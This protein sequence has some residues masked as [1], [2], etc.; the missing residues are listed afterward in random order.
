MTNLTEPKAKIQIKN[1][2]FVWTVGYWFR[3]DSV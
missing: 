1:I 3:K 2:T